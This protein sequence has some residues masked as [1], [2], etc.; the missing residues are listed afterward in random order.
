MFRPLRV[1]IFRFSTN[2]FEAISMSSLM[3]WGRDL[4]SMSSLMGGARSPPP[5]KTRHRNRLK[6][7][8]TKPED[9]HTQGPKYVVNI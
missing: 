7:I 8:C 3:G 2:F 9:G 1:A 5:H 4:D 6:E